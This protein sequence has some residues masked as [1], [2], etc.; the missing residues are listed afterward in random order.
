MV[1]LCLFNLAHAFSSNSFVVADFICAFN[2]IHSLHL[3]K[4]VSLRM[5]HLENKYSISCSLLVVIL[6]GN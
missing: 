4:L 1:L 3:Q 5:P 2:M 6:M